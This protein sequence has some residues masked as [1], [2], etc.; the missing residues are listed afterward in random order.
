M[1]LAAA[2]CGRKE[3][4]VIFATGRTQGR[5]WADAS[6]T[7][8]FAV[9]KNLYDSEQEPRLAVDLGNWSSA[10][11]EGWL[12]KGRSSAECVGAVPYAAAGVG[13]E[14]L[15]L[16]PA[17]LKGV[18]ES[19]GI[20]LLASN[21]YLRPNK[22]PDF[23]RSSTITEAGGR[24]IGI[25]SLLINS[26]SRPD[27]R[28]YLP[29]YKLEKER[30]EA[31]KAIKA[32]RDAGAQLTVML[33]GINPKETA[34]QDYYRDFLSKLPRVDLV[35]TDEPSIKKPFKVK[36]TWVVPSGN[37]MAAAAR[38]G[39]VLDPASGKLKDLHYKL[40]PLRTEKYGEAPALLKIIARH[41]AAAAAYF[42][43]KVGFL[44]AALPLEDGPEH[45]ASDF[46]ADCMR[47]WARTNAAIIGLDET[48]APLSSGTVTLGNL[49]ASFPRESSVVFVKIRGSDL[50]RALEAL[51]PS[52][53][54]VS[55]LRL[56]MRGAA[57]ERSET[58]TGPLAPVHIYRLA[59]PDSLA[60]GRDNP[61]LSSA[62]EFANSKHR[63]RDVMRW[64]FSKQKSYDRPTGARIVRG[65]AE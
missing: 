50:E 32:L 65:G 51:Q 11:P 57:L 9:F 12:T 31:E 56:F 37:E 62:M 28:K 13:M 7:G 26:P 53:I 17:E 39:L 58:E 2:A 46:A 63:L 38:I 35:I 29:H 34:G 49:Y 25:F 18:A 8:G 27:S 10:T 42:G 22:K 52:G 33:L 64:C 23:L 20:P 21:L 15:S 4:L 5:L 44:N 47:R 54:S 60:S 16:S 61:V 40:L 1:L 14:E 43:R 45:P 55:G 48:A 6:G 36:R 19:A 59:V 24:K 30:Y 3:Q 41:R